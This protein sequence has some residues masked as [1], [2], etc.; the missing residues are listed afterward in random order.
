VKIPTS[1]MKLLSHLGIL[2]A[3][4]KQYQ[5]IEKIDRLLPKRSH[6]QK[7]SHGQALLAMVLQGFGFANS[8]LYLS[9]EFFSHLALK[10]LFG[11]DIK[12]EHLNPNVLARTLDAIYEYGATRFFTDICLGI[13]LDPQILKKF[14]YMDTTSFYVTGQ[15]YKNQ[16]RIE[17]KH[18]H[19][20]DNRMDLKQ[21]VYLLVS[22]ED[23]IPI[24]G[25]CYS[26][27]ASDNAIFQDKIIHVQ[28]L[29][30][31]ELEERVLVLDSSLYNKYFLR[32]QF[33]TGDWITRV[34]ESVKACKELVSKKRQLW[35]KI[36]KDFKYFETI[37]NYGGKKQRWIVVRCRE[38]KYK[39]QETFN[40]KLDKEEMALKSRLKKL[41]AR[42]FIEKI[43]ASYEIFKTR[44]Q[45]QN[46]NINGNIV[47][48]KK[49]ILGTKR[50]RKIGYKLKMGYSRNENRI[51]K[52]M[53]SKGK[54][55]LATN[56]LDGEELSGE[57]I[58][59][60]YRNRNKGVE[61]CFK[62]LKNK[63]LNLNQVF[64]QKESRIEAMMIVMTFILLVNNLSE[65]KIKEY[66]VEKCDTFPNQMGKP[67]SN[68]TFMWICYKM[69]YIS[70]ITT[71]L[72]DR[73][74]HEVMGITS[75]IKLIIRAFGEEATAIYGF[76]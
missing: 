6:N 58:V 57:E 17:L 8:R 72:G 45:Y 7:I 28:E 73:I 11:P 42:S 34:P 65:K 19:S 62:F 29:I 41:E 10:E 54:F 23:G 30:R 49:R 75:E 76:T 55:V 47:A 22:S 16:G 60:A 74:Y 35:T 51:N 14:L 52:K 15:K 37:S 59:G 32:N 56:K 70:R 39:E 53:E 64:L 26:G 48:I 38:S 61:G 66:L 9:S 67:I 27:S 1:E 71:K 2:V 21:L 46:F 20:K 68:P 12:A 3:I 40:K 13:V 43:D 24:I 50:Y 69:R 25:E 44:E 31:E 18:G 4:F 36:D 5:I 33:I 63:T